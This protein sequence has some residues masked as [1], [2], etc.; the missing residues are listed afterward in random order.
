M[1]YLNGAQA[2]CAYCKEPCE[3]AGEDIGVGYYE[4]WGMIGLD[5]KWKP[6]SNCCSETLLESPLTNEEFNM[7]NWES[8]F[9]EEH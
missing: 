3:V 8:D 9:Q 7:S 6:I 5:V 1:P 4:Y 2:F